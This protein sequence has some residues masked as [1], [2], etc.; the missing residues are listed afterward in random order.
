MSMDRIRVLHIVQSLNYGGMERLLVDIARL[1]DATRFESHI[2]CLQYLGR[3]S[4]GL[5]GQVGLHQAEPMPRHSM[6]WPASLIQQIKRIDPDVVHTHSGVWYK[7]SLAARW[8]GV[9]HVVHTEH[10]FQRSDRL[11]PRLLDWASC[12]RTDVVV[13]VSEQIADR[14]RAKLRLG[15]RQL[16]TL[17]NGVDTNTIRPLHDDHRLRHELGIPFA[18]PIIGS[19]GRL[20][21]VKGYDVMIEAF[22]ELRTR[23]GHGREP[24][25][26]VGGEGRQRAVLTDMVGRYGLGDSV[27]LLGWRDDIETLHRAFTLFTLSS[28][29]EGTSVGLLEAMAAGRCP[30]V[31][32]VGGNRNVL[33]PALWHRLVESENP[34]A[35]A[36]AWMNGLKNDAKRKEDARLARQR[37]EQNF[38]LDDMIH[39]YEGLYAAARRR[40]TAKGQGN[41]RTR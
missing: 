16:R 22:A 15:P 8:A 32:D 34:S 36:T 13:A 35:L 2:L 6:L 20:E 24:I 12:R 25:L 3:F 33:G 1:V 29:S 7:A 11:A 38:R 28:R 23:W 41:G 26:V 27:R 9:P 4:E 39:A 5:D 21:A 17:Y 18:T 37:V 40:R 10:G 31:T 30:V 19:V 14:L